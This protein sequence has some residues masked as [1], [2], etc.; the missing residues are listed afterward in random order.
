MPAEQSWSLPLLRQQLAQG[1]PGCVVEVVPSI[2]STS[3]E[4]MRRLR[5]GQ[6]QA[7]LLVAEHQSAGRGRLGRHWLSSTAPAGAQ[8]AGALLFSL[9][10]PLAAHHWTGLSLAMGVALADGIHPGVQLKWPNDLW[11]DHRKLAGILIETAIIGSARYAVIGMG[12]NVAPPEASGLH[13]APAWTRELLPDIAAPALLLRV[14]PAVLQALALFQAQGLPAFA[15]AFAARDV[16]REREVVLSD[17]TVGVAR[18][19]D[20]TG[21]LLVHTALGMKSI[22]SSEVSVRPVNADSGG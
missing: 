18:G 10:L 13:P 5:Q 19:I 3:S 7:T 16:L 22:T 17:G 14:L 9:S 11:W 6:V 15:T 20:A 21:G 1:L 12:I 4:L 2:D 8:P